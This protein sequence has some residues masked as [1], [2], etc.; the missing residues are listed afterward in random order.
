MLDLSRIAHG[1]LALEMRASDVH[2]TLHDALAMV[3]E[4]IDEK[5]L[6]VTLALNAGRSTVLG[7]D[8]RLKQVFWNVLKNAAKFTDARGRIEVETL[9]QR[10]DGELVVKITDS[11]IGMTAAEIA[12]IFEAFSQGDHATQ[13][14]P[15]RFG[16]M[17]LGLAISRMMVE[18]HS[19]SISA[20]SPGRNQGTTFHI[21]LPLLTNPEAA[22]VTPVLTRT[23]TPPPAAG[24]EQA[25]RRILLVEDHK[26]TSIT[27]VHLLNRR[28]YAVVAAGCLAEAREIASRE[29]FDLLI[30]DIGLPDGNGYDLMTELH[31]RHGLVGI[32]LT[33][34]GMDEDVNRSQAA[35]FITHL[36]KPVTVQA[37]D[38]ALSVASLRGQAG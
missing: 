36:T 29:N 28:N 31:G 33:G 9:L 35:G 4:E 8:V 2:S 34:Y 7:D 38:G 20:T 27:L 26:P 25:Q 32:A 5:Q 16:G 6:T 21:V 30:S 11:G 14:S 19:G 13:S 17:G 22:H 18:L 23:A 12:R 10:D 3:R 1:K 15:H 37:L 24:P